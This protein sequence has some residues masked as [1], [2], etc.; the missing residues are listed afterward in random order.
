[1]ST[2]RLGAG[3]TAIQPTI[4]DAKG[5]LIVATAAD[6]PARLA[7]GSANQVLTVDSSTATGLKWATPSSGGMTLLS[8]TT[9]TGADTINITGIS[10]DYVDLE[11]HMYGITNA[12]ANGHLQIRFNGSTT[13]AS[14]F[15]KNAATTMSSDTGTIIYGNPL[16]LLSDFGSANNAHFIK[17]FDYAN[18]T[19]YKTYIAGGHVVS[20]GGGAAYSAVGGLITNSAI[21]SLTLHK[22]GPRNFTA[23]TVKIYGVK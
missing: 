15:A 9:L 1:M 4:L 3:D 21:T 20:G 8:T 2:G 19:N 23:G 7:V 22:E 16:T 11:I 10:T 14:Y 18:S 17:V 12:T 6:T 5:D 13:I